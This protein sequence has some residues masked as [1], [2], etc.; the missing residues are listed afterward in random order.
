M[1]YES[2]AKVDYNESK[3]GHWGQPEPVSE[4]LIWNSEWGP[5]RADVPKHR[6]KALKKEAKRLIQKKRGKIGKI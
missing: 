4:V 5:K 6:N 3:F 2:R 1:G